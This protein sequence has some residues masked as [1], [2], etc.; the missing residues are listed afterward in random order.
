MRLNRFLATCGV[1]S[2]RACDALIAEGRVTV[3]GEV[4]VDFSTDISGGEEVLVDNKRVKEPENV[5]ILLNKPRGF[6]TTADDEKGR[7]TIFEL[8][9]PELPRL[10]YVGRLDKDSEGLLL[11]TNDGDLSNRLSHPSHGIEKEY[12]VTLDREFEEKDAARLCKGMTV[13]GKKGRFESITRIAPKRVRVVLHQGLKRQIRLM[14]LYT[15]YKVKA[16]KRIRIGNLT[17]HALPRGAW[18]YLKRRE[19]RQLYKNCGLKMP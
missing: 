16:L 5:Y 12:D 3:D 4:C 18:R 11:L 15:G 14:L 13:E 10:H 8:I 6:I 1:G 9:P 19:I 2:R 17:D 7:K